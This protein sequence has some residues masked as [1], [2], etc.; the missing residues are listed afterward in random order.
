MHCCWQILCRKCEKRGEYMNISRMMTIAASA[1]LIAGPV[2]AEACNGSSARTYDSPVTVM[3]SEDGKSVVFINS[4]GVN[5]TFAPDRMAGTNWQHCSGPSRLR[6][7][8]PGR[9]QRL[10]LR[11]AAERGEANG[12]LGPEGRQAHVEASFRDRGSTQREAPGPGPAGRPSAIS[13][14]APGRATATDRVRPLTSLFCTKWE[15][16]C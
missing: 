14:P 16:D 9:R 13:E 8:D 10:L 2:L 6:W 12:V 3:K 7:R 1:T 5:T 11:G 15:C 4:T